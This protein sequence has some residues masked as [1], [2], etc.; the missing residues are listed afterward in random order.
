MNFKRYGFLFAFFVA[1]SVIISLFYVHQTKETKLEKEPFEWTTINGDSTYLNNLYLSGSLQQHNALANNSY[2]FEAPGGTIQYSE[3][4]S[5]FE[6][7][8]STGQPELDR[9]MFKHR[10]LFRGKHYYQPLVAKD[11]DFI[12][13][14][15]EEYDPVSRSNHTV[16]TS[17]SMDDNQKNS[18]RLE[19][20]RDVDYSWFVDGYIKNNTFFFI[21][22]LSS[23]FYNEQHD[24]HENE[25]RFVY[26]AVDLKTN[27]VIETVFLDDLLPNDHASATITWL[28]CF[29]CKRQQC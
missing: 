11:E 6:R 28:I 10:S 3:P 16:V 26:Y 8:D 29:Q 5:I 18:L 24:V 2:L 19:S 17:A 4:L 9:I 20:P 13:V 15:H 22:S 25:E 1:L 14:V 7:Y 12:A 27:N 23:H 21:A